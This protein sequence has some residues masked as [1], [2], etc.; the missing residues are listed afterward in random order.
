[1]DGK[2]YDSNARV[3]IARVASGS[4]VVADDNHDAAD[5]SAMLLET[6]GYRVHVAYDGARA[7]QLIRTTA[8]R[9]AVL[10]LRMPA[11]DGYEVARHVRRDGLNEVRLIAMSG[12]CQPVD[13]ERA[14][15]CGFDY[16]LRKPADPVLFQT[17]VKS[18][19][20]P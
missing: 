7:L 17:V 2:S 11:L 20:S 6:F 9:A 19:L 4:V 12:L 8:P 13:R 1:M 3:A 15:K 14:L 5:T 10:D 18:F 16:F